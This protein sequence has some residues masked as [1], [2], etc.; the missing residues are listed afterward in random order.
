[1]VL[2]LATLINRPENETSAG[3]N[4]QEYF[5]KEDLEGQLAVSSIS[6]LVPAHA[7]NLVN[8][9][10]TGDPFFALGVKIS[11]KCY[12]I[13]EIS[14]PF[15]DLQY[16]LMDMLFVDKKSVKET[17][18]FGQSEMEKQITAG[19]ITAMY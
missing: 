13:V 19:D 9:K 16:T 2:G 3:R 8:S 11:P 1:M 14:G 15:S 4:F 5:Y 7:E 10:V 18:A 17:L 12:D 6:G